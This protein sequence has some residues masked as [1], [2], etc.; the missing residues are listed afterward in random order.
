[1]LKRGIAVYIVIA[2][3]ISVLTF[4]QTPAANS[5]VPVGAVPV[6]PS[7]YGLA[8]SADNS[9]AVTVNL[10]PGTT[11]AGAPYNISVV[12]LVARAIKNKIL[13][14]TRLVS[15]AVAAVPGLGGLIALLINEDQN[16][17]RLLG[18]ATDTEVPGSPIVVGSRP[19][20]VAVVSPTEA[21][22]TNGTGGSIS[23][24]DLVGLKTIGNP[25]TVGTDALSDPRAVVL[26]PQGRYAYVALG[27]DNLLDVIDLSLNPASVI[28]SAPTGTN[29][30][31]I[32]LSPDGMLAVV[33]NLTNNTATIFDTSNP[34]APNPLKNVPVCSGPISVAAHPSSPSGQS[35]FFL[36]C[37]GSGYFVVLDAKAQAVVGTVQMCQDLNF[38][39]IACTTPTGGTVPSS[40]IR[41]SSD[42]KFLYVL[43]FQ[44]NSNLRIYDLPNL[45]IDPVTAVDLPGEPILKYY[46][47]ST[48]TCSS[49]FYI[50]T[51]NLVPGQKSGE[52]SLIVSVQNGLL[53][54]GFNLGGGFA[55]NGQF[56]G[57]GQFKTPT[58]LATQPVTISVNAQSLTT[59]ATPQLSVV[60][61]KE[62]TGSTPR[63]PVP[64]ASATSTPGANGTASLS[65]TVPAASL[66]QGTYYTVTI[67]SLPGSPSGTFQMQ[68]ISANS[69]FEG[70][71]V[72]GGYAI[73]GVTGYGGYCVPSSQII[74]MV[75]Q[76]V[77]TFGQY[78]SGNLILGVQDGSGNILRTVNNSLVPDTTNAPA[79]P[80]VPTSIS[81]YVDASAKTNGSGTSASPF[82][83]I[84]NALKVAPANAVIFVRAGIYSPSKTGEV[85][86]I[87]GF[88]TGQQLIGAGAATT[89]INAEQSAPAPGKTPNAL[90]VTFP[91]VRIAGFTVTGA[92]QIGL[93]I[94]GGCQIS[95]GLSVASNVLVESN[96]FTYNGRSGF[97]S[98]DAPGLIV[99]NNTFTYNSE[100][101]MVI[102]N[103]TLTPPSTFPS[104]FPSTTCP[105]ST[106]GPYGAYVVNNITNDAQVDGILLSQGGN[107]CIFGNSATNNGSS[108]IEFNN[109]AD[110]T[111]TNQQPLHGNVI[112][113]TLVNN[114]GIQFANA[115]T[116]ILSNEGV[117]YACN[118]DLIQG[119]TLDRNHPANLNIFNNAQAGTITGNIVRDGAGVGLSVQMG[120]TVTEI[121]NNTITNHGLS[122]IFVENNATV[123]RIINNTT[124]S[125]NSTGISILNK[126]NVA[127]IDGNVFDSNGVGGEVSNATVTALTNNSFTRSSQGI[128]NSSGQGGGLFVDTGASVGAFNGTVTN[129]QGQGAIVIYGSNMNFS[130]TTNV[131]N[132]SGNGLQIQNGSKVSIGS[133]TTVS[134]NG[135]SAG[136]FLDSGG[137]VVLTAVTIDS[138]QLAGVQ[139]GGSGTTAT[140]N[141]GVK[142][143][144]TQGYG[145][146]A[147][148]G[149][150]I[151]CSAVPTYS[152]NTKGNVLGNTSGCGSTVA[153]MEKKP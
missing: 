138:N 78:A 36:G 120:S 31:A 38:K 59:G 66:Q 132:N 123:T 113:N 46:L 111:V 89:I 125:G 99:Q 83:S 104:N 98:A 61:N 14:G 121:S 151:T 6:G 62:A 53:T 92:Q 79:A 84:T 75:V 140:L 80:T 58:N 150:A 69:G 82:N 145:L 54:G 102:T 43:E 25:I 15:V 127:T 117:P 24:V 110:S 40:G 148:S 47:N 7:P 27:G 152:G 126:S 29:P 144:N 71:V 12:D 74:G 142:V 3:L 147:Q 103:A 63:T 35:L 22:V 51:A 41:P 133:G 115:G 124:V 67:T 122:G 56:P 91:N 105:P 116:G 8:L 77:T 64:G 141:S 73:P 96:L 134:N 109:R 60:L 17:L 55:G 57:F 42:G 131:S 143:T 94:C 11:A 10:F 87:D 106:F 149:G 1:M 95:G 44:E 88:K 37:Q 68:L 146:N 101:G 9:Q 128:A 48:G 136:I 4:G 153:P 86:P 16:V 93:F 2:G 50:T 100:N 5:S 118:I 23:F 108:G 52:Y 18:L 13:A 34:A 129:N 65:F 20:N 85:I 81:Y 135:G 130:G 19:S 137:S 107:S 119:N 21:V 26:H 49:S 32:A 76:G 70:G 139:A 97:S 39:P 28:A 114:G 30:T 90:I 112:M 33:A 72:V 45:K